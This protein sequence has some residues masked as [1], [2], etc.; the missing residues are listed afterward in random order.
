VLGA[1][2]PIVL[3]GRSDTLEARTAS[4]VLALLLHASAAA[5]RAAGSPPPASGGAPGRDTPDDGRAIA[6]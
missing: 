5:A 6:A 1:R 4:C 3:I 2:V